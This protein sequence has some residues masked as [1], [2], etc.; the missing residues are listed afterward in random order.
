MGETPAGASYSHHYNG[1]ESNRRSFSR[2]VGEDQEESEEEEEI[3]EVSDYEADTGLYSDTEV[4]EYGTPEA[5]GAF[6]HEVPAGEGTMEGHGEENTMCPFTIAE[7]PL[8][9][10]SWEDDPYPGWSRVTSIMDSGACKSVAPISMAPGVPIE[11]SEGSRLGQHYTSATGHKSAN[12][13]QQTL[14][15]QTNEGR[16]V[17][18]IYQVAENLTKSLTSVSETCDH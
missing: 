7:E 13:G 16:D 3:E 17:K 10:L 11:E 1:D 14:R 15:A 2:S 18:A 9:A 8:H 6:V 4:N 5:P 12:L